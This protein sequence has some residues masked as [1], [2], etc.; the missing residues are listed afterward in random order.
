[1]N[2]EIIRDGKNGFLADTEDEWLEKLV[3]L[4]R[5]EELRQELGQ[6]GRRTVDDRYSLKF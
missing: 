6:L 4:V 3:L 2:K 5:D 1:M